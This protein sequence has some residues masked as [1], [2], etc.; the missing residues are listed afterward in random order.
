MPDNAMSAYLDAPYIPQQQLDPDVRVANA[1][2]YIAHQL[3]QIRKDVAGHGTNLANIR[4][5]VSVLSKKR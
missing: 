2:E 3:F 5:H 4:D 1:L